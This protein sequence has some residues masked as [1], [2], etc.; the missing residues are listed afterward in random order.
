MK[1]EAW[2][3]ERKPSLFNMWNTSLCVRNHEKM[4]CT[5]TLTIPLTLTLFVEFAPNDRHGCFVHDKAFLLSFHECASSQGEV[6]LGVSFLEIDLKLE[7]NVDLTTFE[8]PLWIHTR[9]AAWPAQPKRR[10]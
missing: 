5:I 1:N 6:H 8:M 4:V 7:G 9:A 3:S 10:I 2:D